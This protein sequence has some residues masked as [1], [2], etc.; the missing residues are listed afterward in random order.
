MAAFP[1]V[2]RVRDAPGFHRY[3]SSDPTVHVDGT[4]LP[5]VSVSVP[6]ALQVLHATS[7][8]A[9]VAASALSD[10]GREQTLFLRAA[11]TLTPDRHRDIADAVGVSRHTALRART[12]QDAAVKTVARAVGE[13]RFPLLHDWDLRSAPGWLRYRD[14]E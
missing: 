2:P 3:V 5:T 11:R 7:A 4:E 1:I 10:R 14:R 8:V 13:P 12:R 9:R 6:D